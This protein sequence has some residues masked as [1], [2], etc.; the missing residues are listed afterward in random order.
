MVV[1]TLSKRTD[2]SKSLEKEFDGSS[3]IN[4]ALQIGALGGTCRPLVTGDHLPFS[5]A[6]YL[7]IKSQLNGSHIIFQ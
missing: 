2:A 6:I 5:I 3:K 1:C 7:S 4:E